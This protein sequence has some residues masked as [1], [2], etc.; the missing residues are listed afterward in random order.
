ML[1]YVICQMKITK[2]YAR[3]KSPGTFA[4]QLFPAT[5]E[6]APGW[7]AGTCK[8]EYGAGKSSP[9]CANRSM[10]PKYSVV[11]CQKPDA[12]QRA[13]DTLITSLWRQSDVVS[14][15]CWHYINALCARVVCPLGHN[16]CTT[17][18]IQPILYVIWLMKWQKEVFLQQWVI[19]HY[20]FFSF[21]DQSQIKFNWFHVMA[22]SLVYFKPSP[23]PTMICC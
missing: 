8:M 17:A 18:V 9:I 2:Y 15:S 13:H 23:G 22:Y 6:P 16:F 3:R 5:W 19:T 4:R 7:R 10:K 21:T 11:A 14:T 12:P 20:E 1:A